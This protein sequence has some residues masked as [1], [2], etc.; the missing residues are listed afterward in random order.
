M[1]EANFFCL[2]SPQLSHF[3]SWNF[4]NEPVSFAALDTL[5]KTSR[6]LTALDLACIITQETFIELC[7]IPNLQYFLLKNDNSE[8][9]QPLIIRNN[10]FHSLAASSETLYHLALR[11]SLVF[12]LEDSLPPLE[13]LT[14]PILKKFEIS[15][16]TD[17]VSHIPRL[18][19]TARLPKLEILDT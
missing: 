18:F 19:S 9:P 6:L 15:V 5:C 17:V 7:E 3:N 10:F 4:E 1:K 2:V 12:L 14:F 11:G 8:N 16:A 13:Q